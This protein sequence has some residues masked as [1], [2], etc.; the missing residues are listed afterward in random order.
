MKSRISLSIDNLQHLVPHECNNYI[1]RR[2]RLAR[3]DL[4]SIDGNDGTED[5][6]EWKLMMRFGGRSK[7]GGSC[8]RIPGGRSK[9]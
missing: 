7:K 3:E 8:L 6:D 9:I 1:Q 4:W 2:E 5:L